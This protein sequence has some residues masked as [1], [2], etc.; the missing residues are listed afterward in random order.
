MKMKSGQI[1][2][3]ALYPNKAGFSNKVLIIGEA[4]FGSS[5]FF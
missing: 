3:Y 5:N 4:L 1:T 2:E